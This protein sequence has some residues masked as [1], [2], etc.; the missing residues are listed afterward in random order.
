MRRPASLPLAGFALLAWLCASGPSFAAGPGAEAP[1]AA[2][3]HRVASQP[4][5][6]NPGGQWRAGWSRYASPWFG[7]FAFWRLHQPY[8]AAQHG[9][10]AEQQAQDWQ[11]CEQWATAQAFASGVS[12]ARA[13]FSPDYRQAFIA[14]LTNRGYRVGFG[15]PR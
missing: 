5:R 13:R 11:A 9:Q 2:G 12:L 7:G 4:D 8:A 10:N 1:T 3:A 6:R 15:I 14:C